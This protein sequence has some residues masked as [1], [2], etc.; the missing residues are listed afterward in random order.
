MCMIAE[1]DGINWVMG[2]PATRPEQRRRTARRTG[3]AASPAGTAKS[4]ATTASPTSPSSTATSRSMDTKPISTYVDGS[5]QGGALVIPQ[6][7]GV[8]FTMNQSR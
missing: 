6:S 3:S 8:V 1:A 4:T 7:V 2:D 5:G